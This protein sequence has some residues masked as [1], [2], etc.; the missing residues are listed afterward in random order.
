MN[1]KKFFNKIGGRHLLELIPLIVFIN[2]FPFLNGG[3]SNLAK[4]IFL[5]F[6]L[7]YLPVVL[8]RKR[9][10]HQSFRSYLIGWGIFLTALLVSTIF[11]VSLNLSV[12]K[13]FEYL[14]FF[15]YF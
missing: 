10:V 9:K 13:L 11:S 8:M 5:E 14:G 6:P 15:T 7:F 4:V 12:P 3:E 2:I 1:F